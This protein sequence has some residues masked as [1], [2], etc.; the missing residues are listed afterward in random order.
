MTAASKFGGVVDHA[1]AQA[2]LDV[3]R[4][5]VTADRAARRKLDDAVRAALA[6]PGVTQEQVAALLEISARGLRKRLADR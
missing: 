5:A 3:V 2:A 1:A 6:V 4:E